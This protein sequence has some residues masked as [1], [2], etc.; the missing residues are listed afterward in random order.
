MAY[1]KYTKKIYTRRHSMRRKQYL[2]HEE[3]F[4]FTKSCSTSPAEKKISREK[5]DGL[6]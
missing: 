5:P 4:N 2:V 1:S 3:L 6:G